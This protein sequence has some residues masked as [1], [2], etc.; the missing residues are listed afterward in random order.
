MTGTTQLRTA[1]SDLGARI[2]D[3]GSHAEQEALRQIAAWVRLLS[4]GAAEALLDPR[5]PEVVRSRAFDVAASRL[6]KELDEGA[7]RQLSA[8]IAPA[9]SPMLES[10]DS[11]DGRALA[12]VA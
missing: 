9:A 12:S 2:A 4:P 6:V 8:Q 1:L 10:V 3:H 5:S 11:A 7:A